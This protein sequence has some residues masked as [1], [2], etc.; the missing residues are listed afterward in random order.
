MKLRCLLILTILSTILF[1]Q[2]VY[3]F[4]SDPSNQLEFEQKRIY[5]KEF[6][7]ERQLISG[8]G[9]EFNPM[10]L[11]FSNAPMFKT[12]PIQTSFYYDYTFEIIK[13]GKLQNEI[14]FLQ[15]IGLTDLANEIISSYR[16]KLDKYNSN[17]DMWKSEEYFIYKK[18]RNISLIGIGVAS[19]AVGGMITAVG[20][21]MGSGILL[22]VGGTLGTI[23]GAVPQEKKYKNPNPHIKPMRPV[24]KQ[25]L[26]N[27]QIKAIAESHNRKI[28][29]E[30]LDKK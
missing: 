8:G 1:S 10:W 23:L 5:I 30:I 11:F 18:E 2:D 14:E 16:I 7:E 4:F 29:N 26:T 21:D 19:M 17:W 13:N 22:L 6:E 15:F 9:D 25:H 24:F 20:E 12:T 28:F 3:P 27:D